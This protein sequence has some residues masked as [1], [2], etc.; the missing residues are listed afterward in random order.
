MLDAPCDRPAYEAPQLRV[1]GTVY[2]LTQGTRFGLLGD[3]LFSAK[4]GSGGGG[5]V[6]NGS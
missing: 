3:G 1:L 2:E 6:V 5:G 4:S